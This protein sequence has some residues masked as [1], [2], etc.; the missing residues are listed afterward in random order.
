MASAAVMLLPAIMQGVGGIMGA[1]DQD[2]ALNA[3]AKQLE[4][5]GTEALATSQRRSMAER[6]KGDIAAS[7]FRAIAG[8]S[9][10]SGKG[11]SDLAA[12]LE[13]RSEYN[14]ATQLFEGR[15]A[16]QAGFAQA[17]ELREQGKLLKKNALIGAFTGTL[18]SAASNAGK[19]G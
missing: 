12:D 8:A 3:Q 5:R 18:G 15:S 16:Q 14:T 4:R 7:K 2:D 10:A 1:S 9:G 6:K 17:D 13:S 11:V 19:Y